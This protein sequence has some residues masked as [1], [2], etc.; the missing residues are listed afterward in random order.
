MSPEVKPGYK[1]TEAGVIPEAWEARP[2]L[3]VVRLANGQ[4][5]P[6]VEPYKSMPLI[7]PDH[8]ESGTG[9][10]L[11]IQTAEE[12]GAI[13]G[14]YLFSSGDIIYS[15]IR[16]Y[17][18]K[19]VY[20]DFVGL[21]SAD[22]YPMTPIPGVSANFVLPV[23]LGHKF[24]SYAETVSVR[25]GMPKINR[26]ELACFS[27]ALPPTEEQERIGSAFS[28]MDALIS[29]LNQL[30]AK[31]RDI[32]Q[33]AMQQL[34]TGQRRLPGFIGERALTRL[35]D[36]LSVRHGRNQKEVECADGAY[37]ILAT[38]GEIGR[39]NTSLY[40]KP[41]VLIGRKGTIDRP[42]Y[43]DN[44]FWTVD[45]LFYTELTSKAVPKFIY[46]VF[47]MIDWY[48][49]NEAS[50]VPSLNAATIENIEVQLPDVLEQNA[51][52]AILSDMDAELA[53][54]ET[55]R[56]KACQLKRGMMQELLTGRVRLTEGSL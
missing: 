13:S 52:A 30:I 7:A 54:L 43:I 19:V 29:S 16:P 47:L 41:S 36:V 31:K 48:S 46:Y 26:E 20:V 27:I 2:L 10:L 1:Q 24:S 5:D 34:L 28:D 50:G 11:K 39:T 17:L 56:D 4:V 22:M 9:T 45:T 21:C 35:G 40:E 14:K 51:I 23:L 37:P 15:K 38:G 32:Q 6:T 55:R 12:Q 33:A 3:S 8:I 49:Y 42:M 44:P 18:K 25:S 53:I